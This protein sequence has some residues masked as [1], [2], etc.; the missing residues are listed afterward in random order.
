[1]GESTKIQWTDHT[2]NPWIGCAKVSAGCKHCYAEQGTTAR[3]S[4]SKGLPLW[5]ESAARHVT[6]A[7]YWRE[8]LRWNRAAEKEGVRRRVFCASLA[9]VF[10]ARPDLIEPRA[11]LFQL[12]LDTPHLDWLLL[13]KR[14][15]NAQTLWHDAFTDTLSKF[16]REH[17]GDESLPFD[18][19]PPAGP[20]LPNIWL[21]TTCEDQ[22][23]ANLRIPHLLGIPAAIRFISYEPALGPISF[24]KVP[25]FNK[26]GGLG[27]DLSKWWIIVGGE[28]GSKARPFDI[29]WAR[30]VIEQC[31]V[32]GV[33]VFVKQLGACPKRRCELGSGCAACLNLGGVVGPHSIDLQHP[34]GGDMSEWP[35]DLR[36]RE[37][38]RGAMR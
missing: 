12:V 8:P 18:A 30:S 22:E 14:P 1:M 36:V 10:E 26:A 9:D 38:P 19:R 17:L 3:I 29:A 23:H 25:G 37:L 28:S 34:K 2:F 11:R 7:S 21:G 31:A 35:E 15:E 27:P 13:T 16:A 24:P 33:P 4:A 32:P 6:S 5:G 20:W